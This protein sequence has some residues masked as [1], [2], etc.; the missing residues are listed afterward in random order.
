MRNKLRKVTDKDIVE[1]NI[2]Y[3]SCGTYSGAAKLTGWSAATVKKYIIQGFA[4]PQAKESKNVVTLD[5][6][7]RPNLS[8]SF[9]QYCVLSQDEKDELDELRKEILV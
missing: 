6:I 3:L 8:N 4:M 9:G 7:S 1:M 5:V 2:A